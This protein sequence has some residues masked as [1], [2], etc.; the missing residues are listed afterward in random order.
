[1]PSSKAIT[2]S[3]TYFLGLLTPTMLAFVLVFQSGITQAEEN[4]KPGINRHYENPDFESWVTVFESEGREVFD[5]RHEIVAALDLKKGM[6][7]ADV[8]AGTGFF[9]RLFANK[10]GKSGTVYAVDIARN[11]VTNILR[12]A[13]KQGI[14]NIKGIVSNQKDTLLAAKSVDLV[15]ISDTYHHFEYPESML[16]SINKAL[17]SNGRLVIIDFRKQHGVSSGWVMSHVRAEKEMV[18][19][20]VEKEGFKKMNKKDFLDE[21]YFLMFEKQS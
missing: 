1:M 17:R 16:R 21:N 10:I 4:V 2:K 11:F 8:G 18:I 7:V 6:S 14:T 12:T 13:R 19:L 3:S 5:R 9:S 15:F 20:E